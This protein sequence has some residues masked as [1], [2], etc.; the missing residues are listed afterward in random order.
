MT[1][2]ADALED[3]GHLVTSVNAHGDLRTFMVSE[4]KAGEL[5]CQDVQVPGEL[6]GVNV[7]EHIEEYIKSGLDRDTMWAH[8]PIDWEYHVLLNVEHSIVARIR[9]QPPSDKFGW[10]SG[11]YEMF[12]LRDSPELP[13][14][15]D[16]TSL[17]LVRRGEG[18]QYIREVLFSWFAGVMDDPLLE[19]RSASH[20]MKAQ[21]AWEEETENHALSNVARFVQYWTVWEQGQCRVCRE[22]DTQDYSAFIPEAEQSGYRPAA[23]S[24]NSH[25]AYVMPPHNDEMCMSGQHSWTYFWGQAPVCGHCGEVASEP[26]F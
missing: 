17:G 18:R 6:H 9:M 22:G 3:T 19:C 14:R 25:R 10:D 24:G 11:I 7:C 23:W 1:K 26:P 13:G 16:E 4:T 15:E 20:G 12:V 5:I 8:Q 2:T 21:F